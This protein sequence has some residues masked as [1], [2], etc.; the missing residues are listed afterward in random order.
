MREK[1]CEQGKLSETNLEQLDVISCRWIIQLEDD[2]IAK[3]AVLSFE[4]FLCFLLLHGLDLS[5][6]ITP[7]HG[8]LLPLIR[9]Q[10]IT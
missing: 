1:G 10:K 6:E 4:L 3:P 2:S 7:G 5:I 9:A 8:L